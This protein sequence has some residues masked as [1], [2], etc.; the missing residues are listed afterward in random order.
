MTETK[1]CKGPNDHNKKNCQHVWGYFIEKN[2]EDDRAYPQCK[3]CGLVCRISIP[4]ECLPK[5]LLK[6]KNKLVCAKDFEGSHHCDL[7]G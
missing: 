6:K 2:G 4:I 7:C 1:L 3:K 5:E